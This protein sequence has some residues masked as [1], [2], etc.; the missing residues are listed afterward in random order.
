MYSILGNFLLGHLIRCGHLLTDFHVFANLSSTK[1]FLTFLLYF[2]LIPCPWL[3]LLNILSSSVFCDLVS[4]LK[5]NL[6][7]LCASLVTVWSCVHA[8]RS[9][10]QRTWNFLE[11]STWTKSIYTPFKK[12][13]IGRTTRNL[14]I[15]WFQRVI[16]SLETT[17]AIVIRLL[18]TWKY[19][20]R[21]GAVCGARTTPSV[22]GW[23]EGGGNYWNGACPACE[24]RSAIHGSWD[25]F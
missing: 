11:T 19:E 12:H 14:T 8:S 17:P 23:G 6:S 13:N 21:A 18:R 1:I 10:L 15:G 9:L 20:I 22:L 24:R 5:W 3:W 7:Q 2:R 25:K 4:H 16:W